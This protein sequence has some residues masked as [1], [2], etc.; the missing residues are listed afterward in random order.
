MT[1]GSVKGSTCVCF[2]ASSVEE[3]YDFWLGERKHVR[4]PHSELS[5]GSTHVTSKLYGGPLY[6]SSVRSNPTSFTTNRRT[7]L[8]HTLTL[9]NV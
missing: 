1:F 8:S 3:A 2:K 5:G 7:D 4:L 6:K 9:T